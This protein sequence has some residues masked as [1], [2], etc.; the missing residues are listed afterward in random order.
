LGAWTIHQQGVWRHPAQIYSALSAAL[1]FLILFKVRDSLPQEGDLFRLY[2]LLYGLSRF[3]IEFFRE[4]HYTLGQ[5]SMVQ[6]I[7]L[8]AAIFAAFT[9]YLSHKKLQQAPAL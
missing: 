2:L 4:R 6:L 5:L 8:E 9:L 1:L 3:V 7:C